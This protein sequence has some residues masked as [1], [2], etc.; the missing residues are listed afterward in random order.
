MLWH[1]VTTRTRN[2]MIGLVCQDPGASPHWNYVGIV[3]CPQ[4]EVQ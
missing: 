2:K 3:A 1:D 4:P